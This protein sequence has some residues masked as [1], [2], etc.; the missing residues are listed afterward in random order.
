M[1]KL[2]QTMELPLED[3]KVHAWTYA[4]PTT[5]LYIMC[6]RSRN[7][8]DLMASS[9]SE[10]SAGCVLYSDETTP[11]NQLRPD[12]ARESLCIY[13]TLRELPQWFRNRLH[14][15]FVMGFLK[16]NVL[17]TVRGGLSTLMVRV[18]QILFTFR[19]KDYS[20][21]VGVRLPRGPGGPLFTF[22]AFLLCFMQDERAHKFTFDVKGS[23]GLKCCCECLNV[24]KCDPDEVPP[25]GYFLH[26]S[27]ARPQDFHPQ[28]PE[29]IRRAVARLR[30]SYELMDQT[31]FTELERVLG[32]GYNPDGVLFDDSVSGMCD[33][34]RCIYEDPMHTLVASGGC[35]QF[36]INSFLLVLKA[37]KVELKVLDDFCEQVTW[38]TDRRNC[39]PRDFSKTAL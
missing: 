27:R 5:L 32:I 8:A 6:S 33:P 38:P 36:E 31:A 18:V 1:G 4:D 9:C 24:L 30:E 17:H 19:H 13:H 35:A 12:S 34:T 10:G 7:F 3:G 23:G 29:S 11:G 28:T 25:G 22:R 20:F 14:G 39:V 15:W 37:H 21:G 26:V 16:T 2:L